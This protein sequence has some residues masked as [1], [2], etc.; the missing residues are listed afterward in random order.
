MRNLFK[1]SILLAAVLG[2]ALA[3]AA[4]I[5]GKWTGTVGQSEITFEFKTQGE[6]VTGTL[7]NAAQPGAVELKDV[8]VKGNDVS[9]HVL[10][11]LNNAETKVEWT[12]KLEGEELK[13]QRGAVAGNEAAPVVAKRVK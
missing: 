3:S 8:K 4:G 12:G 9:F 7:D 5:D 1:S 11:N 10:R 13:L 6:K 2:T